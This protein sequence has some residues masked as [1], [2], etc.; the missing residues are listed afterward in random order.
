MKG[1]Y[2]EETNLE[3]TQKGT[4]ALINIETFRINSIICPFEEPSILDNFSSKKCPSE[5]MTQGDSSL[6]L[7]QQVT[8]QQHFI[9]MSKYVKTN[10]GLAVPSFTQIQL[11]TYK[12]VASW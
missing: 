6:W 11:A 9:P 1:E 7:R 4:N 5:I 8:V 12:L 3:L 2:L 10:W